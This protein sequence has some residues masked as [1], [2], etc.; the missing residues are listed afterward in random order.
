MRNALLESLGLD[1][2]SPAPVVGIVSRL[3][4]QKGFEL[5][6]QALPDVLGRRDVRI[7]A[8]GSGEPLYE[9]FFTALQARF[10]GR[11]AFYRGFNEKLAHWIEAGAD[12]FLMPSRFEPCGL[13]QM[14]SLR[15]G[16]PPIV[17][18]T[19]GLADTVEPFDRATGKGTGFVFEHF[20]A[21]GLR[22]A[23]NTA[24]DVFDDE[25]AWAQLVQNGMAKD[26]SW[27]V[28]GLEYEALFRRLAG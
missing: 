12:M 4:W 14:Y 11:V 21:D 20:T 7:V 25:T 18:K 6:F 3:T 8:L 23:L 17:R 16:T 2:A 26:F 27:D 28:Q 19:G 10:P 24:L 1:P 13:N 22:W 5:C 9:D 15:Y